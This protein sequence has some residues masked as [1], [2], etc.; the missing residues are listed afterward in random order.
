[1]WQSAEFLRHVH[2]VGMFSHGTIT[3]CSG[4]VIDSEGS[5]WTEQTLA[6]IGK[7][8]SEDHEGRHDVMT[9]NC[10]VEEHGLA[11]ARPRSRV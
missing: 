11:E 4:L 6:K 8:V 7:Q 10:Q 1:M 5:A 9:K 2:V 3:R